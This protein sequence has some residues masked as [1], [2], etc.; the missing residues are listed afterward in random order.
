[1]NNCYLGSFLAPF[2]LTILAIPLI[3]RLSLKVGFVDQASGHQRRSHPVPLGGGLVIFAGLIIIFLGL[4]ALLPFSDYRS[5]IGLLAGA[6]LIFVIGIYD[7]IYNMGIWSRMLG[8]IIA[9]LIFLAFLER[10]PPFISLPVY[11]AFGVI[12]IVGISSAFGFLDNMDGLCTGASMAIALGLGILFVLRD[13][14]LFAVISFALAGGALGF[15]RYNLPPA[16]IY[17]GNNGSLLFGYALSCLA[18]VHLISSRN[19]SFALSPLLIMA[20]PIFDLTFVTVSRLSEGRKVYIGARDH[21][22]D[23]ITFLGLTSRA[24]VFSIL[25]VNLVLVL[26]GV[27]LYFITGSPFQTLIIVALALILAFIGTHLYRSIL[28]LR[29]KVLFIL[30]DIIAINFA[31]AIYLIIKNHGLILGP[32]MASMM[33]DLVIPLAWINVFWIMIYSGGGMYDIPVELK[34]GSHILSLLRLIFTGIA[35]FAVA[36]YKGGEG[37]QVSLAS[38]GLFAAILFAG[39]SLMR[40]FVYLYLGNRRS[41]P[42]RMMEAVI[43]KLYDGP[44]CAPTLL[45]FGDHYR[46]KGYVE[47]IS[48]SSDGLLGSLDSLGDILR[49]NHVARVILDLPP[50]N[51]DNLMPIFDSAFYMETRFLINKPSSDNLKGL[52]KNATCYKGIYLLSNSQKKIFARLAKRIFDFAVSSAILVVCSPWIAVKLLRA[53]YR[54]LDIIHKATIIGRGGVEKSVACSLGKDGHCRF[55]NPWGLWAVFK[56]DLSLIGA[57]ITVKDSS[58]GGS[59]PEMPGQWRKYLAKPGLL[60]PGYWGNS[61]QERF[62]MDLMYIEKVSLFRDLSVIFGQI[63]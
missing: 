9:A 63:L 8:Q 57:T 18:I 39:N 48:G 55:R 32:G 30:G 11:F 4:T 62:D 41:R 59:M 7:D 37:F 16:G 58:G 42:D 23:K 6:I 28:Y 53:R 40:F 17:L 49:E 60:G 27:V 52:R 25:L 51:Y 31:F 15:L 22:S 35:I 12:W 54:K 21:S 34:P 19:L 26:L 5:A 13:M 50:D 44:L 10:V 2:F 47:Q 38:L 46:I 45:S 36:T 1:M 33:R 24:T 3:R 14:P 43:V 20:Y 61:P 29:H 56:G